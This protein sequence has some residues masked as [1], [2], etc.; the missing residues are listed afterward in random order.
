MKKAAATGS[1]AWSRLSFV[2]VKIRTHDSHAVRAVGTASSTS[3]EGR[4]ATKKVNVCR[5]LKRKF[6]L[7]VSGLDGLETPTG[8][9][10]SSRNMC[11]ESTSTSLKHREPLNVP[12]VVGKHQYRCLVKEPAFGRKKLRTVE[13]IPTCS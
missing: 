7:L 13:R 9:E 12:S 6:L 10:A 3:T 8:F 2:P 5:S 1:E 4:K 11:D